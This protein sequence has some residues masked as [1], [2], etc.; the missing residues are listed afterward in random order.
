MYRLMKDL[1]CAGVVGAGALWITRHVV[2]CNRWFDFADK[3][4]IVTGGSRG[5]GLVIARQLVSAGARVAICARTEEDIQEAVQ[6]LQTQDSRVFGM[7]CDVRDQNAVQSF[8][9]RTVTEFGGVDALFNVAGV[10][11]VGPLEEMTK[12]DFLEAMEINCWGA[13]HT[14]LAVL[15]I[16]RQRGWGRIVNIA[17]IGGKLSIPHMIPYSASKFALVGL[18]T[19]LHTELMK[20]G[21]I[22]TTACPTMM[23]TGSPRNAEFKGQHR[24]E[25]AWFSIGDALPLISMD[26]EQAA[27]QI[28]R[29]C[30][31]GDDEVYISNVVNPVVTSMRL[32][33]QLTRE[34]LAMA[35]RLLPEPGGIGQESAYGY[36]SQSAI[37][38][39]ILTRLGDTAAQR[40]NELRPREA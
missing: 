36:E 8:V 15:P 31:Y 17:S 30:Q 10:M 16:M 2:R 13:L 3:S 37:T 6:E 18:S 9:D 4:V 28:I 7:T 32:A 23:R 29:A 20:E 14:M 24:K 35:S 34:I 40:N 1:L 27:R 25:F 39:S 26:A 22:V 33:P 38:P 12:Q 5:L 19:G 11:K 21:I